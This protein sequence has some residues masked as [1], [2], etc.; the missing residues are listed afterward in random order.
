MISSWPLLSV[1][2]FLPLTGVLFLML[3][4]G[5]ADSIAANSRL[6]ALWVSGFTFLLSLYLYFGF[7]P[8]IAG[9][10]F[11][12]RADWIAG[13]GISYHLGIDGI[14]MPFI[15]LATFLTP[16]SILASWKAITHRVRDYMIAFLVLEVMMVGMFASLDML[17]FYLFFEGV[18]IPM[19]IIIGVWGG[20]ERV[21]AAF[22][23]F[24]YTLLGS[25]LMLVCMLV[26]YQI[27]GTT[28]IPALAEFAF[29]P[30]LQ[31]WLFLGFF[32]SFAVKV[33]MW[34][35]H[36]WLPDAHVQAPTAGSMILAGVLLK[37]GGYGFLR[38][39][40]PMFP[41]AS[42]YFAPFIFVLS[43]VAVIYTSLVAL[44][45][46]D[47]KKLIAYSSVAHMGFVTIG[48]F[49]LTE[50]GIAGAMFQMISHGLVSAALFFCVGVVYDRL[51][52]REISA[53]GG[54]VDAMPRYAA[55]FMFMML[56]SVGLPGT[57]GFVGEMLVLVGAW[58][59]SRWVAVFA[60][61]GLILGACYMLWLYRRVVFGRA[62]KPEVLEMVGLD[63]RE[64]MIFV[65]LTILVLWF[66]V[67]PSTLLDVMAFTVSDIMANVATELSLQTAMR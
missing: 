18:L 17:M 6:V 21:Y 32:A 1:I 58:E 51:H 40:L 42:E 38:F 5:N 7:D 56:A 63:R 15:L 13:S 46:S 23:F 34:P 10:Q 57:S 30:Q 45:Q 35:V 36:T 60:A 29:T 39:S 4:R 8:N 67:Y 65:P 11:E 19:F 31:F 22:K 20:A 26:M 24:L 52:T 55:F 49:T 64:I 16:L 54:V 61:T 44:A 66:G 50:Q 28:D 37:M 25:V 41:D 53:Y 14:S 59:A 2:T 3:I 9:Y 62:E 48:I 27:T 33:P 43:V 47:M 12:E